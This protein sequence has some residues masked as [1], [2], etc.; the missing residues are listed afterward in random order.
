MRKAKFRK[1][2]PVQCSA[3]VQ[4]ALTNLKVTDG[5]NDCLIEVDHADIM[6]DSLKI[7]FSK[8]N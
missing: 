8:A 7:S 4:F 1:F 2:G 5:L 3:M 6:K